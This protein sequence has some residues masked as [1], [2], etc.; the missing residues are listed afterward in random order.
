[1]KG[2]FDHDVIFGAD[3]NQ[4]HT[5]L[6]RQA[7]CLL[8]AD[9]RLINQI[10]L[11]LNQNCCNLFSAL[12]VDGVSPAPHRFKTVS[13]VSREGQYAC[14]GAPVVAPRKRIKLFL[15]CRIPDMKGDLFTKALKPP[16]WQ[17][18]LDMIGLAA[19]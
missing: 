2:D 18:A 13:I 4:R 17:A 19:K 10:N 9:L 8:L 15:T 3:A 14:R 7:L 12:V 11:G 1:M 5:K 6:R 16:K